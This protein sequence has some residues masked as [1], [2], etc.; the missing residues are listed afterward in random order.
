MDHSSPSSSSSEST[1]AASPRAGA[2]DYS[3]GTCD[4]LKN[5][6]KTRKSWKSCKDGEVV[7][8]LELEAALLEGLEKYVPQDTRETRILGRF[9]MRNRFISDYI[10]QKTGK[11]RSA[12]QVGSRIQQLRDTCA[13]KRLSKLLDPFLTESRR[14]SSPFHCPR[15]T[16]K[17]PSLRCDTGD[18]SDAAS[19]QSPSLS[20]EMSPGCE[21]QFS[22]DKSNP[23]NVIYIDIL[24]PSN[25][26]ML[27]DVTD[28][29]SWRRQLPSYL[30]NHIEHVNYVQISQHPRH[31]RYIDPTI[32]LVSPSII[33]ARSSFTVRVQD[34]IVFTETIALATAGSL[35]DDCNTAHLYRTSLVPGY[36]EAISRS[37]DPTKVTIE[38]TVHKDCFTPSTPPLFSAIYKFR[39]TPKAH[40]TITPQ[41]SQAIFFNTPDYFRIPDES[42]NRA[43]EQDSQ[44]CNITLNY[45]IFNTQP[46]LE[47]MDDFIQFEDDDILIEAQSLTVP[48]SNWTTHSTGAQSSSSLLSVS[49]ASS[50]HNS[51]SPASSSMSEMSPGCASY[52]PSP[53]LYPVPAAS[54]PTPCQLDV[55]LAAPTT[56]PYL[57]LDYFQQELFDCVDMMMVNPYEVQSQ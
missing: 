16:P 23:V 21:S 5:V 48:S 41:K 56:A 7:W 11:R 9:P 46:S 12:K 55:Q 52:M 54:S 45:P 28:Q 40:T 34:A 22:D 14:S 13:G 6:I 20:D 10:W 4:V 49:A 27:L 32:T 37:A 38:Q 35:S 29:S 26:A 3:E 24:P 47:A 42:G 44:P 51:R 30:T 1:N 43:T 50:R 33:S 17:T 15:T 57:G 8:P 2:S 31:L 25:A 36:W 19:I 18:F 53:I 39:V